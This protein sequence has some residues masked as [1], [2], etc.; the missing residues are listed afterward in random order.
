MLGTHLDASTE[1]AL[2]AFMARLTDRYGERL[3]GVFLFGSR[4]EE[5]LQARQRC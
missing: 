1:H 3:K 5:S 2:A 4:A